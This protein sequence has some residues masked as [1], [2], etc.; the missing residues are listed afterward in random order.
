MELEKVQ[1]KATEVKGVEQLPYKE[2]WERLGLFSL[3]K[4]QLRRDMTEVYQ[5]TK[6]VG[7]VKGQRTLN[8]ITSTAPQEHQL[9]LGG[10]HW[11]DALLP[12][13]LCPGTQ[14]HQGRQAG[15]PAKTTVM[16][17]RWWRKTCNWT[18]D[19]SIQVFLMSL[20]HLAW[21]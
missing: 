1:R 7:K 9:L 2:R 16:D 10:I 14:Q 18:T 17:R 6:V 15:L 4:R 21:G 20:I 8:T 3:E 5:L 12:R 13:V 19:L 11:A